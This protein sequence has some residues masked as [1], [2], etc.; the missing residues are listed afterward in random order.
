MTHCA[1]QSAPTSRVARAGTFPRANQACGDEPRSRIEIVFTGFVDDAEQTRRH[2]ESDVR[3]KCRRPVRAAT[4]K[5]AK[6]HFQRP[7]LT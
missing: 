2:R 6:P 7:P 3:R 1:A 5:I 4:A